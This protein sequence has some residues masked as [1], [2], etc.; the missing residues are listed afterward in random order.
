LGAGCS[1][2]LPD[3]QSSRLPDA[4][5]TAW[6]PHFMQNENILDFTVY[7]LY[8]YCLL[9]DHQSCIYTRVQ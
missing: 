6:H 7:M 5:D 8:V 2:R 9:Y 1:S 3:A 4:E